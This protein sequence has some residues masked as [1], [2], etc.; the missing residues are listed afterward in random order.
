MSTSVFNMDL[1]NSDKLSVLNEYIATQPDAKGSIIH[2]LHKGQEIFGYLPK[3]LQLYIAR[4]TDLPAAKV[5]GIVTFYSFFTEVPNGKNHI[6]IC[7]GTA[8]FV[9]GAEKIMNEFKKELGVTSERISADGLFSYADVRCIGACGLAPVVM[10]G[11]KVYGN[12]KPEDVKGIVDEFR[13]K[14]A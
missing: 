4:A 10:I 2:I 6:R 14:E 5:N 13:I 11:E 8:C 9:K 12:L 7:L 1:L 3:E